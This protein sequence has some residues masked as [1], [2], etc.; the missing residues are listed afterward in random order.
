MEKILQKKCIIKYI[1]QDKIAILLRGH[2]RNSF[3][4]K[5]LYEFIKK[6]TLIY[7]VDIYIYT[8]QNQHCE[9]IYSNSNMNNENIISKEMINTYFNDLKNNIKN[10]IIDKKNA[11]KNNDRMINTVSK[12]K[13]LHMWQSIYNVCKMI[14]KNDYKFVMNMRIDYYEL[15]GKIHHT[16]LMEKSLRKLFLIDVFSEYVPKINPENGINLLNIA[17]KEEKSYFYNKRNENVKKIMDIEF[18]ADDILYGID[19]IISGNL[20]NVSEL[21]LYFINNMDEIFDFYEQ[22]LNKLEKVMFYLGCKGTPHEVLLPLI[23]KNKKI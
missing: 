19:N 16:K 23:I 5:G 15:T 4:K 6:M 1:M 7:D 10:I 11:D 14:E 21:G 17:L 12:N 9:N 18:D 8:F 13:Y 22:I 3:E 20:E 2:V